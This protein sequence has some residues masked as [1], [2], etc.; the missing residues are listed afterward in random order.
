MASPLE[1]E[2]G[3]L[4]INDKKGEVIINTLKEMWHPKQTTP[5]HTENSTAS[6][7]I[8]ETVKNSD[9]RL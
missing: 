5:M 6:G 1:V 7:I 4:F 8:N 2:L 3:G 9:P